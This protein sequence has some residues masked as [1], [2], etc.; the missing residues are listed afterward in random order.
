[1]SAC[2]NCPY[3]RPHNYCDYYGK[4]LKSRPAKCKKKEE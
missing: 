3:L 4:K 1:M 2:K